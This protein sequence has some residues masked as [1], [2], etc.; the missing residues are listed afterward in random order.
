MK[1]TQTIRIPQD[2]ELDVEYS[3]EEA[4]AVEVA[5]AIDLREMFR[6]FGESNVGLVFSY[7]GARLIAGLLEDFIE[8]NATR[9]GKPS[10][11]VGGR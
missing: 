10:D 4:R 3:P 6:R 7:N 9:P 2:R 11:D 8:R 1:L 5:R